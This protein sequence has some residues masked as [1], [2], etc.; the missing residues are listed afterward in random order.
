MKKMILAA[1]A[2]AAALL[3]MEMGTGATAALA[4]GTPPLCQTG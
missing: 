3:A 4:G 1:S 2:A